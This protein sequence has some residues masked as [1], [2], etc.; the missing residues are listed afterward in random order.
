ME[1]SLEKARNLLKEVTP[2]VRDCGSIC[3]RNC[4]L[5][6][7]DNSNGMLLFPEEENYYKEASWC[8]IIEKEQGKVLICEGQCPRENRPLACRIFPLSPYITKEEKVKSKMD[9]HSQE[10]CP[11]YRQGKKALQQLFVKKV[12]EALNVLMEEE[13]QKAFI[14]RISNEEKREEALWKGFLNGL[15]R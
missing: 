8:K 10:I 9:F 2:L 14:Y 3:S 4:C 13:E 12:E 7:E 6:N 11:L 5:P 15:G 1:N